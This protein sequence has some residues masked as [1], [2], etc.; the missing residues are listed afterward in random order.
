M[1]NI[2]F[3]IS[4]ISLLSCQVTKSI[5]KTA[6]ME[7]K[8]FV[9]EGANIYFLLTDRFN[10][11]DTTNDINFD[12]TKE[13]G[14][15]RGFEGGDIKGITQ[16]INEGYFTKLGI[17]AI[18]MTPIVEQIH[19]G[20]D[21]G[22]GL[23]YGFHGYWAKDWT[24][25]DPNFGTKEDLKELVA[26]AHKNGIRILLDAVINHTGPVTEQDPVWPDDWV[27]TGP[28]CNYNTYENTV[29]CTLVKNLP[30][31]RTE[32][33]ENVALPPQLIAKWK[34]EGRFEQEMKELDDFFTRTGHPRAPRFYIMKWLTDYIAEYGID[35]YRVD[36]VKHTEEFVWQEFKQECDVAFANY[37]KNNP[38]KVLDANNFYLVGEVY[39]YGISAG[40][41]FNFGNKKVNYFDKAFNSL[42]NFEMKWNAK[43]MAENDVFQKYDSLLHTD[44]KGYGVLN[45]MTSHDDG[46]PFD[47]ERK[48][49]YKTATM[50]LLT[51]GTSQVYYGDE[52]ARSLI[53]DGTVGDATLRSFMNWDAIKTQE[54]TQKILM[55]WQKLGQFRTNHM[56]VGA[57]KHQLI[58]DE[59][60]LVFSRVRSD[61][62]IIVGINLSKGNKELNVGSVFE[63]GQ[64]LHDF[65]S[66]QTMEVI[67]GKVTVNSEFDIVLLEKI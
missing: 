46:E 55:H 9:W 67:D 31:I 34:A 47:K 16:K 62:K 48:M 54:E 19:G 21:E 27:R 51:P 49:P 44:L 65:Y 11:G 20:V 3:I 32:S 7:T 28:Q 35:G 24:K 23:S 8:E 64:K 10:N 45:Y 57:G 38:E 53:I 14:K 43:Q 58:S 26:T 17:N 18:W 36:T 56:A 39:N 41:A 63:N 66:N 33:N 30:D 29:T 52:S 60:G 12:R 22:T 15:L 50:L 42:I 13:T 4:L 25:I 5:K 40:K 37:K 1:K 6:K 2:I 61:D 59:N